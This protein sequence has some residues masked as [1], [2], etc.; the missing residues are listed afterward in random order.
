MTTSN[1][2]KRN[3]LVNIGM[4]LGIS[5]LAILSIIITISLIQPSP[6][7]S[8]KQ[9]FKFISTENYGAAYS[10][11]SGNYQ[12]SKGTLDDFTAL[13]KNARAHGTV[14][15]R[16]SINQVRKTNRKSQKVVA[17][18]LHT[19]EKGKNTQASGQYVLIFDKEQ[20]KWLISDSID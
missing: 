2:I 10:L 4:L 8:V 14:Y 15:E 3:K 18:T 13:F 6:Q 17:F 20:N 11:L 1:D 5:F 19:R 9:Y 7:K 16:V 12:K